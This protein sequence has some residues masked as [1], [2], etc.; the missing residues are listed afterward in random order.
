MGRAMPELDAFGVDA[1]AGVEE[2]ETTWMLPGSDLKPRGG[3]GEVWKRDTPVAMLAGTGA[4]GAPLK[5]GTVVA[6]TGPCPNS[7]KQ[8]SREEE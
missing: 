7:L 6:G 5:T 1:A 2:V 8:E 3:V 4:R